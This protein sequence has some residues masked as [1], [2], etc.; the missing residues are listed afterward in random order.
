MLNT[1]TQSQLL[2]TVQCDRAGVIE[3]GVDESHRTTRVADRLLNEVRIGTLRFVSKYLLLGLEKSQAETLSSSLSCFLSHDTSC[4]QV[5][6]C[7]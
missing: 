6:F 7:Q 5:N 2:L 4:L 1:L 3:D